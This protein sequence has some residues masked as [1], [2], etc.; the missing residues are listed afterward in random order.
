MRYIACVQVCPASFSGLQAAC[1]AE[2]EKALLILHASVVLLAVDCS[3]GALQLRDGS[4]LVASKL[5]TFTGNAAMGPSVGSIRAP[6][7]LGKL[8]SVYTAYVKSTLYSIG[9]NGR[10]TCNLCSTGAQLPL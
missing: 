7:Y 5:V 1:T 4:S 10:T 2:N 6:S 8:P 3:G 9:E